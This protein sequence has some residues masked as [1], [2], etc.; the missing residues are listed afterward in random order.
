MPPSRTLEIPYR[1]A[2]VEG[3]VR[4]E[5]R[6][7]EDPSTL[8]CA[9]FAR[10]FPY[11]TATVE[12]PATGYASALGWVQLVDHDGREPGFRIDPFTPLGEVPHPFAFFGFAPTLFDAPHADIFENW[13]FR[14][15]SFL[16]GLGGDLYAVDR[17]IQA[18]LGF[19]WGFSKRGGE[20][21]FFGPELLSAPD[22]DGH[23][24]YLHRAFSN[25]TF[26]PGFKSS[27][28]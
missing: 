25:W 13:D 6:P 9:E 19:A 27:P 15:H 10:G 24:D 21:E 14:A 8:G 3:R 2:G 5:V 4:V 28:L 23:L 22:W 18:I 17:E 12:P 26:A 7:N 1:W 20:V 11:C 16:C